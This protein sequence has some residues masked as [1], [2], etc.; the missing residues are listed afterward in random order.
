MASLALAHMSHEEEGRAQLLSRPATVDQLRDIIRPLCGKLDQPDDV[1]VVRNI[2]KVLMNLVT[3][4]EARTIMGQCSAL[5]TVLESLAVGS[6]DLKTIIHALASLAELSASD[7]LRVQYELVASSSTVFVR[8][9][10]SDVSS[11]VTHAIHLLSRLLASDACRD[12]LIATLPLVDALQWLLPHLNSS[13]RGV[14]SSTADIMMVLCRHSISAR[15]EVL[16]SEGI[17]ER[18]E[19][20]LRTAD[21]CALCSGVCPLPQSC[22]SCPPCVH[23]Y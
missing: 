1:R 14:A 2:T 21:E 8:W 18:I 13:E 15:R 9:M 12:R 4:H 22:A 5:I 17:T 3:T 20:L 6:D 16:S 19:P 10:S 7:E 23:V 11:I